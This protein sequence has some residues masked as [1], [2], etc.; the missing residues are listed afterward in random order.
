MLDFPGGMGTR[1]P[2]GQRAH[3]L[4]VE[5]GQAGFFRFRPHGAESPAPEQGQGQ[6]ETDNAGNIRVLQIK[7][8]WR[9]ESTFR[10]NYS[11]VDKN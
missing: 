11:E 5:P 8:S 7:I 1:F 4:C 6:T 3:G 9:F 2:G 10:R